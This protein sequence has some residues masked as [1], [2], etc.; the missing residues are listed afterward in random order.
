MRSLSPCEIR[1]VAGGDYTGGPIL[2]PPTED[3]KVKNNNGYGNGAEAGPPPGRSGERNPQLIE[4]N[5]GPR[6]VR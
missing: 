6:G 2:P 5:L 1:T 3:Y 4:D